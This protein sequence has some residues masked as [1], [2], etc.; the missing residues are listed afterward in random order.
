MEVVCDNGAVACFAATGAGKQEQPR[1]PDPFSE[2]LRAL[3]AGHLN[4]IRFIF[5]SEFFFFDW[6]VV[7][8]HT[9]EPKAHRYPKETEEDRNMHAFPVPERF[10]DESCRNNAYRVTYANMAS[11]I[12]LPTLF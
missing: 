11:V 12:W 7:T 4:W 2:Q 10:P 9:E 8:F 1:I 6:F 5:L 3:Y